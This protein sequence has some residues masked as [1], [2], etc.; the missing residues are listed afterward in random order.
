MWLLLFAILGQSLDMYSTCRHL[1]NGTG[2]EVNF[3]LGD[4]CKSVVLRK[5]AIITPLLILNKKSINITLGVAGTVAFT[6]NIT[7]N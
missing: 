3:L 1:N 5:S 4:T 7:R 2:R 6:W